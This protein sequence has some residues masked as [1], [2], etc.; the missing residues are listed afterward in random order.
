M[1]APSSQYTVCSRYDRL[2]W[3]HSTRTEK[4][5]FRHFHL[6]DQ[7]LLHYTGEC[8]PHT[9]RCVDRSGS[10]ETRINIQCTIACI[11]CYAEGAV[12]LHHQ[13]QDIRARLQLEGESERFQIHEVFTMRSHS[14]IRTILYHSTCTCQRQIHSLNNRNHTHLQAIREREEVYHEVTSKYTMLS[15]CYVINL[16]PPLYLR[17]ALPID[18]QISVAGCTVS[19]TENVT[20][21]TEL[22]N[23][24]QVN[25]RP[26]MNASLTK[27]DFLDYGEKVVKPG[28][29]LHL[30]TVKTTAKEGDRRSLLVVRVRERMN[31]FSIFQIFNDFI[32]LQLVQYLEKD[33]SCKTEIP[34]IPPEFAVWSFCSYD[35][36]EKM[37]IELGVK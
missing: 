23:D 13:L 9:K 21:L 7:K 5:N 15:A 6:A 2:S 28:D 27:A 18:I 30:P 1:A 10:S 8:V 22:T 36:E 31:W 14:H 4:S 17:N 33:W 11:V 20:A 32:S 34:A 12:L 24:S 25:R 19:Q 29:L 26:D 3:F 16:K 35:S 37:S